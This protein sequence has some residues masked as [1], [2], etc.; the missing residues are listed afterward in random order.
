VASLLHNSGLDFA[1]PEAGLSQ[2]K[3]VTAEHAYPQREVP[4]RQRVSPAQTT[5]ECVAARAVNV[6]FKAVAAVSPM[7]WNGSARSMRSI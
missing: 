7:V 5:C 3:S 2:Q 1:L 6:Q 4:I